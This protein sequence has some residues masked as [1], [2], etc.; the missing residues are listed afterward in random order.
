MNTKYTWP[1]DRKIWRNSLFYGTTWKHSKQSRR[2]GGALV[3]LAPQTKLQ[4]PQ[5][6][7][8]NII[9]LEFLLDLN[10][11]PPCTNVKPPPAQT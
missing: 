11:K 9:K 2:H 6:E 3:G 10:V 1:K 7:I 4:D 5:I 8:W